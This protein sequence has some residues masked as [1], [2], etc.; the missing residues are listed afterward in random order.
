MMIDRLPYGFTY[1]ECV[2]VGLV[3]LV[4]A[5]RVSSRNLEI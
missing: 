1:L 3:D 2:L 4:V 5:A